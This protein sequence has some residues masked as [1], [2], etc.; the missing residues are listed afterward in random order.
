[1]NDELVVELDGSVLRVTFNRPQARNAMTFAMYE[2][3]VAA[4]ERAD[5][6]EGVR[7]VLLRG[8][9]GQAF[10]AGTD[11]AQFAGFDGPRGV[12]YERTIDAT[13]G[14]LL[15]V[16]VPVVAAIDGFCIGGGLAIAAAADVRVA[17]PS[18]R[19]GYPIART[20]G[21]TL[22]AASYALT[23][24][25]FGHARTIDMITTARL[26]DAETAREAGFVSRLDEDVTACAEG[27]LEKIL[28]HAPLTMAAGKEILRRLHRAA[29][30]VDA[31]DVV[32]EVYGS[33][34]FAAGVA[35]FTSRSTAT[36]T[37]S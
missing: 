32:A 23:M 21:N 24:R 28:A 17:H 25:H 14:R 2:G 4:C 11:I 30:R 3:L 18:S 22:S 33:S 1:M 27:V 12:E 13:I 35:A 10:V 26:L 20:L 34:D 6:D 8:A 15:D 29:G 31:D 16:R 7:A 19:F 5:G 36:W 37:G 9:G